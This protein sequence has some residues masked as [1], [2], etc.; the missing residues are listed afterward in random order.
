M[1]NGGAE[2]CCGTGL[3]CCP[4]D[5]SSSSSPLPL[6]ERH[7]PTSRP[8]FEKNAEAR[9]RLRR[10]DRCDPGEGSRSIDRPEPL[11]PTLSHKGAHKGRGSSPS[12]LNLLRLTS[13]AQPLNLV[14][15]PRQRDVLGFHIKVE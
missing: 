6:W 12:L 1:L 5:Q 9:L 2:T 10:I 14:R 4:R 7:R 11:T 15:P 13:D 3:W 8:L